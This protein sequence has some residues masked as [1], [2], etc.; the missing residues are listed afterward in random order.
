MFVLQNQIEVQTKY[1]KL[2]V[3]TSEIF[4]IDFGVHVT[5][6][7]EK[8]I[9]QAIDDLGSDTF[10]TREL[11]V[12]DLVT[13]G[14][15]AYPL[16]YRALKSDQL[17][18][19]KRAAL[20]MDKIKAKHPA[21]NLRLREEDIITTPAFT[22]VG[23]ISTPVLRAKSENFGELDLK[24][25]K[26]RQIRWI[27]AGHESEITIDAALHGSSINQWME[28]G[29]EVR[30]GVRLI[31][32]AA[33]SVNLWPQGPGYNC[34]PKGYT[35]AGPSLGLAGGQQF[36]AG[37]LLGRIGE[38]GPGFLIGEAYEAAPAKD[39][40]LYLLIVPSPWNNGSTGTYQVKITPKSEF[41]EG[42]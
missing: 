15:Q 32:S 14:P 21:R 5:P 42:N 7:L 29:F 24:L 33:G 4:K 30:S 25:P 41:G 38:D 35:A 1:G 26:L 31:I 18:V 27:G 10:R 12:K 36:P 19:M 28:T 37:A 34:G 11:A 39:G 20:A 23:K 3:P 13:F 22:I 40:K 2:T 8:R 9:A 16:V 17:E 6:D